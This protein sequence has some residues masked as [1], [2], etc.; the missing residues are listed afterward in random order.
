MATVN[1]SAFRLYTNTGTVGSP[2]YT[3][4]TGEGSCTIEIKQDAV[5]ITS[6]DSSGWIENTAILKSWSGSITGKYAAG[7]AAAVAIT[8]GIIAGTTSVLFKMKT[9]DTNQ[10]YSGSILYTSVSYD[11]PYDNIVTFNIS[12]V[13]TGTLTRT[14]AT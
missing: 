8:T 3:G 4:I 2:V 1:G 7:D 12:F 6:K 10:M 14:T 11:A 5:D 13:G 9:I